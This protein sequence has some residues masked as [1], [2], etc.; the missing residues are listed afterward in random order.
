VIAFITSVVDLIMRDPVIV[1]M[2]I[3]LLISTFADKIDR[4]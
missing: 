4:W 1:V 3:I 2:G